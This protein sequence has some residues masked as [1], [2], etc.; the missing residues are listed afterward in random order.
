[1]IVNISKVKTKSD[2]KSFIDF[3]H[4]LYKADPNYVPELYLNI[5]EVLSEKKNPFFSHSEAELFLAKDPQGKIVGRIAAILDNNYNEYHQSNVGFF[6]FFDVIEDF[7]V[8]SALLDTA[9]EWVQAK[10]VE[11]ILGPTNFTTNDT[12]GM[13]IEGYDT[14]PTVMMTYNKPYYN[15]FVTQYGF[16]K[17][18]DLF[19]YYIPTDGVNEKSLRLATMLQERLKR[20]GITIRTST[21]KTKKKDIVKIKEV[22]LKAWEKNWGFVPPT[23]EEYNHLAE[24]LNLLLDMRYV[25]LAEEKGKL[26][27]FGVALPDINEITKGFNKGRLLPFNFIKLLL[28]KSKVSLIRII[29]LGILED[30]RK[31]GIE[32]VF[33]ANYIKAA[34]ENNL[35]A[36]EA[37]WILESN[38]M[39]VQAAEKLNGQRYKTYRIYSKTL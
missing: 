21:K 10:G 23:D 6:G 27:G 1:M 3:P 14:P 38:T 19:A 25:Y 17:E 39:M 26:I 28:R 33:F 35:R 8:A 12:A 9:L 13:L 36:G 15:D 16:G 37:S 30:Y 29:L 5:S 24:G 7:T 2:K 11:R 34:K 31:M 20:K 32:A 22:Y 18:M 4:E